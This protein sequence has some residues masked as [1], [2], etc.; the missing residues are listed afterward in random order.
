M[1]LLNIA[2][3]CEEGRVERGSEGD[4]GAGLRAVLVIGERG[5]AGERGEDRGLG[6]LRGEVFEEG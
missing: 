1:G 6:F 5:R 3:G 4:R 2:A